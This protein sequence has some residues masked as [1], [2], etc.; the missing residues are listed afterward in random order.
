M[1]G[2]KK[3]KE[4]ER[5]KDMRQDMMS[6]SLSLS[7]FHPRSKPTGGALVVTGNAV[8]EGEAEEALTH[9]HMHRRIRRDC[10]VLSLLLLLFFESK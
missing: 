10:F 1:R 3:G 6:F 9:T 5:G 2:Q 4:S 7:L 8:G